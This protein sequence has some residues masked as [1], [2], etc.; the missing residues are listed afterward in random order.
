MNSRMRGGLFLLWTVLPITPLLI[1][2]IVLHHLNFEAGLLEL[3]ASDPYIDTERELR[4]FNAL[5]LYVAVD[6]FHLAACLA[7]IIAM[8]RTMFTL[9]RSDLVKTVGVLG[10]S[11]VA[12]A[13]LTYIAQQD[14]FDGA[15]Y[16]TYRN[17]CSVIHAAGV[18]SHLL[19]D[20]C[21][22]E[23]ISPF[24]WMALLPLV[25]GV[26][27]AA[28]SSA[29][30]STAIL[31]VECGSDGNVE[32]IIQERGMRIQHAFRSTAFVLVTSTLTMTL[33]F[34]LPLSI[35]E[36]SDS[37]AVMRGYAQGMTVFWG[38]IFTLTLVAIF[39]PAS[40][41]L[42]RRLDEVDRPDLLPSLPRTLGDESTRRQVV[43]VLTALAPL[44]IGAAGPLIEA[45]LGTL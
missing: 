44:L 40:F 11:I 19:P 22:G 21:D 5:V 34:Q 31:P 9:S 1:A 24:A 36:D 25:L 30:V 16:L 10:F 42:R 8:V 3:E 37:A 38:T 26:I 2:F 33:F 35:I 23:G 7:V 32:A 28:F 18:G 17:V 43:N 45:V 29:V 12:L 13:L 15:L 27:A 4:F 20:V 41:F 39:A 6:L 14:G